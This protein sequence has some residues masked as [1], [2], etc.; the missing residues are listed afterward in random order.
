MKEKDILSKLY[1]YQLVAVSA[2][3]KNDKGIVCM[4]TGTGKTFVQASVIAKEILKN[5]GKFGIY[6]I[7]APRIMLSYQ[8]LK[9]VMT[10]NLSY[11]LK[12]KT[13]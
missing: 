4:P 12:L 10:I 9:E 13:K 8:L 7:N 5:K 11:N 3:D 1:D 2:T 6:V